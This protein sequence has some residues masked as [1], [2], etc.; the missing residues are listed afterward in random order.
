[1]HKLVFTSLALG[2]GILFAENRVWIE[3]LDR[4]LMTCGYKTPLVARSIEGGLLSVG[5]KAY[6]HGLG[7]H[8]PSVLPVPL[9]GNALRF[10]AKVGLDDE[11]KD[12][13]QASIEFKVWVDGRLAASSG[14]L[15]RSKRSAELDVALEGSIRA[16]I[17][18]WEDCGE[19]VVRRAIL[20]V[21][22]SAENLKDRI[23]LVGGRASKRLLA[24]ADETAGT[25]TYFAEFSIGGTTIL[26]R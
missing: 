7:T 11:M 20:T 3:D 24:V 15:R 2:A 4:A 16:T 5:G 14:V 10:H 17:R 6:E 1:M 9:G 25:T 26:F 19:A 23:E 8:A 12:R 21:P 13:R 18:N 22:S